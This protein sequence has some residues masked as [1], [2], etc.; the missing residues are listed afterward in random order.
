[1]AK[2][3]IIRPEGKHYSLIE[4]HEEQKLAWGD[5]NR[6]KELAKKLNGGSGFR[7][8]TPTFIARHPLDYTKTKEG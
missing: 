3:Y 4:K 1:M 5:R 7:G 6:I 8:L 2:N